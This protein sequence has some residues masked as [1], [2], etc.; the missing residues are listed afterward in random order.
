MISFSISSSVIKSDAALVEVLLPA[1]LVCGFRPIHYSGNNAEHSGWM[2]IKSINS[3]SGRMDTIR[4][5]MGMD[6]Y[7]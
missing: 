7:F 2:M 5:M 6:G 1:F 3:I 4:M